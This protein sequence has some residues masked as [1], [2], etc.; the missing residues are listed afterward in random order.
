[1]LIRVQ[2]S[3][4][5][6]QSQD[7]RAFVA[8]KPDQERRVGNELSRAYLERLR[9]YIEPGAIQSWPQGVAGAVGR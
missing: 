4:D 1:M 7:R 6:E 3:D 2:S 5:E 8:R 9:A